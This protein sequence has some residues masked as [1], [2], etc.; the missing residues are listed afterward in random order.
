MCALKARPMASKP[1][2]RCE[3]EQGTRTP[4]ERSVPLDIRSESTKQLVD[5]LGGFHARQNMGKGSLLIDH[6]GRPLDAPVFLA[7][8]L[9][10]HPNA[11]AIRELVFRIRQQAKWEMELVAEFHVR[12]DVVRTDTEYDGIERVQLINAVTEIAGLGGA[13]RRVILG[14]E[15]ENDLFSA[16]VRE[17]DR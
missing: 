5:V 8:E 10:L 7:H 16:Q 3:V 17:S 13:T 2:P 1:A 6:E 12:A 4:A 9:L 11:V 14:V 15:I